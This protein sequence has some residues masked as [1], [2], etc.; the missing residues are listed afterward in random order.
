MRATSRHFWSCALLAIYGSIAVL[1][2]G[3]HLVAPEDHHHGPAAEAHQHSH[4]HFGPCCHDH[5][6]ACGAGDRSLTDGH[7]CSICDFLLQAVSQPAE[8]A[9][10]VVCQPHAGSAACRLESFHAPCEAGPHAPR[11]PPQ[12]LA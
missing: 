9:A 2:Q 10:A 7:I 3:L 4:A 11:G 12:L 6:D 5:E 1:G 8:R